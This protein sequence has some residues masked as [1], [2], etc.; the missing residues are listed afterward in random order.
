MTYVA[1]IAEAALLVAEKPRTA[2]EL[3]IKLEVNTDKVRKWLRK[4]EDAGLI[5]EIERRGVG[6]RPG[7]TGYLQWALKE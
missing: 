5:T 3:S 7:S 2:D 6:N 4:M 1:K